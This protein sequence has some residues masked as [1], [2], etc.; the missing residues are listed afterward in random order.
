[1]RY[2]EITK[3]RIKAFLSQ[4]QLPSMLYRDRVDV[5]LSVAS[6]LERVRFSELNKFEFRKT[7]IGEKFGPLWSTHWFRVNFEVPSHW[8]GTVHLRWDSTSEACVFSDDGLPLQGLTGSDRSVEPLRSQFE[9]T[10]RAK[11]G[12]IGCYFIEMACNGLF[13]VEEF[14]TKKH[15]IGRLKLAEIALFD[16]EVAALCADFR[17]IGDLALFLPSTHPRA[18]QALAAANDII[19]ALDIESRSGIAEAREIAQK[20]LS[21]RAGE[22]AH[23]LSAIGHAHI[24]TAWL[25]PIAETKRKCVRTFSTALRYM[26]ERPDYKFACSQAAQLEWIKHLEPRLYSKIREKASCGQFVPTGGTW[27]EPDCNLPS[28]ESL[29]RQFLYG[30]RFFEKEFGARCDVFWNP[31]VFGYS[32]A[33]P[34]I[35]KKCG[36]RYFLTQKLSWNQFNKP[37]FSTFLWEGIDGSTV[38]THFPPADTYNSL[39][40]VEQVL[41]NVANFKDAD[42]ARESLLLFGYGDGGGGPTTEML[43]NLERMRNVDGLPKVEMRTPRE[44]FERAE[45]DIKDPLRWVGE[46]YFELHRGTFT[47]QA[48]IKA[49]NRTSEFA[50]RQAEMI[51][52]IRAKKNGQVYPRRDLERLWKDLLV[53]QFHDILPGSSIAEVYEDARRDLGQLKL[54][55]AKLAQTA[56][57]SSVEDGQKSLAVFNPHCFERTFWHEDKLYGASALSFSAPSP[58][59]HRFAPCVLEVAGDLVT[60]R[61]GFASFVIN[62]TGQIESIVFD[63]REF[64]A[65]N[66]C[67]NDFVFYEDLPLRWDAWDIDIFHLE[68]RRKLSCVVERFEVVSQNATQI[69]LRVSKRYGDVCFVKQDIVFTC[70]SPRI[71]FENEITWSANHTLLKVEFATTL[72]AMRATYEIQFGT[73]ERPTHTN[74]TFDMAQFEVCGQRF[75]DLSEPE[76]GLALLTDNKYGYSVR[77]G[78]LALSLLRSPKNPDPSADRGVHHFRYALLPHRGDYRVGRVM[79][80]AMAFNEPLKLIQASHGR[81]FD[82]AFEIKGTGVVLDTVKLAEDSDNLVLRLYE[83]YGRQTRAVLSSTLFD[84]ERVTLC[85]MLEDDQTELSVVNGKVELNFGAFEVLT[86]KVRVK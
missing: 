22:G 14:G 4:S 11:G 58:V 32:G 26:D 70:D 80:E 59:A 86:L 72:R 48:E 16:P 51:A 61:N 67:A 20:F 9:I 65:T 84:F 25:W 77:R 33:L 27:V 39:A 43:E 34:Q 42:R 31:D 41:H 46:L 81:Q 79:E 29:V 18:G 75:A 10:K 2:T 38:L 53:T 49:M 83:F 63:G 47:T 62:K 8:K 52:A 24:D 12:E 50:L 28:G 37:R 68:K 19:N 3:G 69:R 44:F 56:L 15:N 85:N 57:E 13:G 82:S 73:V 71:E 78:T 40:N 35:M 54:E 64:V 36:I 5:S 60:L 45:V 23:R 76:L 6:T 30:Q 66:A 1:M 55:A 21:M 17:V 7:A 74:T